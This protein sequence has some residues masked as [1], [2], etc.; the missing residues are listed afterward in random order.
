MKIEPE[1]IEEYKRIYREEYGKDISS[2]KAYEELHALV[3]LI[4]AVHRHHNSECN[5]QI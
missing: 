1:K 4:D 2:S 5:K 3:C